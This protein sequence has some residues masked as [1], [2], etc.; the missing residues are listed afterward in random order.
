MYAGALLV[1]G[2]IAGAV[3]EA[4]LGSTGLANNLQ[5]AILSGS[6]VFVPVAIGIAVLKYRLY[7]LEVV[8]R[9]TVVLG[10]LA[11]FITV[12]YAGIVGASARSSVRRA[13]R[14]CRSSRLQ[15]SRSYS[16]RRETRPD[17]WPTGS[18]TA[19][20]PR[21]TRSFQSSPA[22]SVRLTPRTTCSRAWRRCSPP[23]PVQ[24]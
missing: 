3:V 15:R 23:G 19:G 10:L 1:V 6:F 17:A 4:G 24:R 21:P 2:V 13:R 5:N 20:A 18:S 8:I 9:K 22:A 11:A 7:D 16:S 14:A 12:V